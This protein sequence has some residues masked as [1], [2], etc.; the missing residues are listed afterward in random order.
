MSFEVS[1]EVSFR[2]H[3]SIHLSR[4]A[5]PPRPGH[6][7]LEITDMALRSFFFFSEELHLAIGSIFFLA[8]DNYTG[9]FRPTHGCSRTN[10]NWCLCCD[11]WRRLLGPFAAMSHE[12]CPWTRLFDATNLRSLHEVGANTCKCPLATNKTFSRYEAYPTIPC[13]G[14]ITKA[15]L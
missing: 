7:C 11:W 15:P 5:A 13:R 1:L 12:Y 3:S 14:R 6:N 2:L 4:T 9:A 10:V 8:L